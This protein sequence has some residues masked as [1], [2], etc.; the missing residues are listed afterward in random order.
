MP[1]PVGVA[2]AVQ[3]ARLRVA[4]VGHLRN[5]PRGRL[6]PLERDRVDHPGAH[7]ANHQFAGLASI[8][9]GPR[10]PGRAGASRLAASVKCDRSNFKPPSPASPSGG[11]GKSS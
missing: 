10:Q 6:V 3:I 11:T 1:Q 5:L 7:F 9:L 4:R 8:E 2:V